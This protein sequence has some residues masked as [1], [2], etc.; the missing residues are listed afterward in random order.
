VSL[1]NTPPVI[2]LNYY[3]DSYSGF[4]GKIDASASYDFENDKL[5]F[6]W[7]VPD[8]FEVSSTTG[9]TIQFLAPLV[10]ETESYEF[11]LNVSDGRSI[12]IQDVNVNILPYKPEFSA[13][14]ISKIHASDFYGNNSPVNITDGNTGTLWSSYGTD[15]WITFE[16]SKPFDLSYF[17][18]AF[19]KGQNRAQYF[20]IYA[21]KDSLTWDPILVKAASCNF[22]GGYQVF[23]IPEA[24]TNSEYSFIKLVGQTN[25]EDSWNNFSEFR[26]FGKPHI[27]EVQMK[28]YPNPAHD[29][30]NIS[31]EYPP[32]FP[33][34]DGI[35]SSPV[36][37][38]FDLSGRLVI[39]KLIDP[40]DYDI[41]IPINIRSGIYIVQMVAR[42]SILSVQKLIVSH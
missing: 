38:L 20:D 41:Q 8:N 12:Q 27:Y 31:I 10:Q 18:I 36:I 29:I 7:T 24:I 2:V 30:V 9:S 4:V 16:L 34:G 19:Q 35:I 28:I 21:S 1:F 3:T 33:I 11:H 14:E 32:A 22:A 25:S 5:T 26:I 17:E 40:G 13:S 15:Q 39:E 23:D 37:R 42:G 6:E